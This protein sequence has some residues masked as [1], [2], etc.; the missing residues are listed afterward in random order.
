MSSLRFIGM[1]MLAFALVA[2]CSDEDKERAACPAGGLGVTSDNGTKCSSIKDPTSK[3]LINCTEQIEKFDDYNCTKPQICPDQGSFRNAYWLD[4]SWQGDTINFAISN[5]SVGG[6][7]LTISKVELM[8]DSRCSFTFDEKVHVSSTVVAAGGPEQESSL[9]QVVF[10]PTKLGEDHAA[11]KLTTN[12]Q[13]FPTLILPI[14]FKVVPKYNAGIDGG[15]TAMPE[16]GVDV[17]VKGFV[18]KDVSTT[19][20]SCTP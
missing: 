2:G 3:E 6:E 7:Q 8:G 12:A 16:A 15:P 13:N 14:C 17:L 19:P 20:R 10:K 9:I 18:C 5:C 1:G 4:P 11:L